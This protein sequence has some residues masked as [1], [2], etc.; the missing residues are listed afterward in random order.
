MDEGTENNADAD[1]NGEAAKHENRDILGV[2]RTGDLAKGL[3]LTGIILYNQLAT[4]PL[5]ASRITF[6]G[7]EKSTILF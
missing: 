6:W 5:E 1:K 3:L 4:A 2:A 7:G